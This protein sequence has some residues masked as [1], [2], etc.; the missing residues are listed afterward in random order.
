MPDSFGLYEGSTVREYL[1]FFAA[2]Y[3]TA[4]ERRDRLVDDVLALTDLRFK[5]DSQV[6]GLS[7]NE[8]AAG[9]GPRA[10]CTTRNCCCSTSRRAAST[11]EPASKSGEILKELSRMGKTILI[12]S[13][14]LHELSQLCTRI[15]ILEAGTLHDRG[16]AARNLFASA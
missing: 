6:D 11:R 14:I 5:L 1:H 10:A 9:P 13:H 8:A 16:L 3:D 7:R 15:G 2:A 12:S 4:E